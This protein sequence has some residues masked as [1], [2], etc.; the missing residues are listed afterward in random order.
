MLILPRVC[1]SLSDVPGMIY[2]RAPLNCRQRAASTELYTCT[3][4]MSYMV[5]TLQLNYGT[6]VTT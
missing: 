1:E 2:A 3:V 5:I 6:G 4:P